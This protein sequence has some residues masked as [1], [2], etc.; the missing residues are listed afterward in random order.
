[1][2]TADA[3]AHTHSQGESEEIVQ[4]ETKTQPSQ[5]PLCFSPLPS[6]Y[7]PAVLPLFLPPSL[8]SCSSLLLCFLISLHTCCLWHTCFPWEG[9]LSEGLELSVGG[10]EGMTDWAY[11][12]ADLP[13]APGWASKMVQIHP[14]GKK[15]LVKTD[16][17]VIK[18]DTRVS[19]YWVIGE[20][21]WNKSMAR[22]ETGN[23]D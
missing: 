18:T 4:S 11:F 13:V 10:A 1:M 15:N 12:I 19:F 6:H 21:C 22:L 14:H 17:F 5:H 2:W 7:R 8:S 23:P 20:S 9:S 16:V 3:Q